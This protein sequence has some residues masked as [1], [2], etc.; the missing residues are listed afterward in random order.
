MTR[1]AFPISSAQPKP[2][3]LVAALKWFW[4]FSNFYGEYQ[5]RSLTE[6]QKYVQKIVKGQA[7]APKFR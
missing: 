2:N 3:R 6:R 1:I 4:R 5:S 7:Q